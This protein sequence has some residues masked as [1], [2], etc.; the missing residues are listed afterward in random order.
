MLLKYIQYSAHKL[1]GSIL[2]LTQQLN[3]VDKVR[4]AMFVTWVWAL[5]G[6]YTAKAFESF[7]KLMLKMPDTWLNMLAPKTQKLNS[8]E[9]V[10]IVAAYD[11]NFNITNKFKLFLKYYWEEDELNGGFSF[12]SLQRLLNCSMLYCT[13]LMIDKDKDIS[14]EAFCKNVDGFLVEL[15]GDKCVKYVSNDLSDATPLPFNMVN[16]GNKNDAQKK[17]ELANKDITNLINSINS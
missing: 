11:R 2:Y 16:F 6:L 8:K 4:V 10:K 12:D 14:P 1:D 7:F 3:L 5:F 9:S 17:R 13:Y 15:R